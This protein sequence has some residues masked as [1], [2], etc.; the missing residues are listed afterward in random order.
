MTWNRF[1]ARRKSKPPF[2]A[3][4]RP[5]GEYFSPMEMHPLDGQTICALSTP[6]GVGGIAVVRVSG[7]EAWPIVQGFSSRSWSKSQAGKAILTQI[8]DG[9]AVLDEALILPFVA[10]ASFTGEDIVECHIH[11]SPYIQRRLLEMMIEA[12]CR[13]ALP[14][15]FTQR[16]FLHGK[17]DLAQS[18]AIGDLIHAEHAGAHRL[19]VAQ[20]SGGFSAEVQSFREQ[21]IEFAAL[22]ELELDF[23]EEDVE[24]ADR[25]GYRALLME[26]LSRLDALIGSFATGRAIAEGVPVAILGPPNRGKSTLLNALLN[27][28]RAIV[29]A[30]PGTTRDVIEQSLTLSGIR[31]RFSDTAGLRET[32]DEIEIE[33]IRRAI[34]TARAARFVIY[35]LDARDLQSPA[36]LK[37][38]EREVLEAQ[39]EVERARGELDGAEHAVQ[40]HWI[41]LINKTDLAPAPDPLPVIAGCTPQ[42]ISAEERHGLAAIEQELTAD[43]TA[44]L[45]S[46]QTLVT[47]LRHQQ[48]L[49]GAQTALKAALKALDAGLSGDLIAVDNRA[50]L[51]H[52]GRITGAITPDDLLG[53]IFANFC[54]GK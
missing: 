44:A 48:A 10:P 21:L 54:I 6:H 19:A 40:P 49:L 23:G 42:P 51:A 28:E 8:S 37:A 2:F 35:L 9:S 45:D 34:G 41:L 32:V 36:G 4:G 33:G 30:T 5:F 53:H 27:E 25:K 26:L 11:G 20:L 39:T 29:S 3:R 14:G 43:F 12:G 1:K 18:E 46:S 47:N 38:A 15:E 52:L 50:A 13:M 17:R 16:A 7:P 24:F 31:F 22:M